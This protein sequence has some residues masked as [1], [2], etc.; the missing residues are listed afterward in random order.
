[1]KLFG[2]FLAGLPLCDETEDPPFRY[3][4]LIKPRRRSP[5]I[6]CPRSPAHEIF[7]NR[8]TEIVLSR[9]NGAD[10]LEDVTNGNILEHISFYA[11]V[12]CLVEQLFVPVHRQQNDSGSEPLPADGARDIEAPFTRHFDVENG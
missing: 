12:H 3:G 6:T 7:G 8:R 10:T 4:Q 9:C 1:M 5:E 11:E 2:D